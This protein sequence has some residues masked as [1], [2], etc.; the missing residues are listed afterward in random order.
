MICFLILRE[1]VVNKLYRATLGGG[2]DNTRISGGLPTC[3][4]KDTHKYT[5]RQTNGRDKD[6]KME[7]QGEGDLRAGRVGA[8][9]VSLEEGA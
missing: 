1:F 7:T 5:K 2:K 6:A 9:E 8:I 3:R 4:R